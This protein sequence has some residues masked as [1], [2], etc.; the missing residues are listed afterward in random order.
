MLDRL[1]KIDSFAIVR[2]KGAGVLNR[3]L[4]DAGLQPA[5]VIESVEELKPSLTSHPPGALVIDGASNGVHW[6]ESGIPVL[7]IHPAPLPAYRG[8]GAMRWA[9]YHDEPLEVCITLL[10][11]NDETGLILATRPLLVRRGDTL[12]DIEQRGWTAGGELL[13]ETLRRALSDGIE[14]SQYQPWEGRVFPPEMP[15]DILLELTHRLESLEYSH[16]V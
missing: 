14:C 2:L 7:A 11:K 10:N 16:Y 12:K 8:P 9:L 5:V 13:A 15:D 3:T 4:Q 1:F 6:G